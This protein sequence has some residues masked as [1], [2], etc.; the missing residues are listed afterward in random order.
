MNIR[1]LAAFIL[2]DIV[3]IS[4]LACNGTATLTPT[5]TPTLT[6]YTTPDADWLGPDGETLTEY[7]PVDGGY[8]CGADGHRIELINNPNATNPDWQT[9]LAFLQADQTDRTLYNCSTFINPDY[10]ETLH[11]NAEASGIRTGVVSVEI[12]NSTS[13]S[14]SWSYLLNAFNVSYRGLIYIDDTGSDQYCS[15]PFDKTINLV[16]NQPFRPKFLFSNNCFYLDYGYSHIVRN[17]SVQWGEAEREYVPTDR[18]INGADGHFVQLIN[19]PEAKDPTW[20]ELKDFL[21]QDDTDTYLYNSSTFVCTDYAELLHNNAEEA[22]IRA[23]FVTT[24]F[25]NDSG[26]HAFNAFNTSDMGLLYIDDTGG[27]S[28]HPCSGDKLEIHLELGGKY[29]PIAI[30]P[31]QNS[32]LISMS[33][34]RGNVSAIYTQ[35]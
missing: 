19:N 14:L 12:N 15:S 2:L 1:K 33:E 24:S 32:S 16:L 5:T 4:C 13:G 20:Q 3:L 7:V 21:E 35:W 11:N 10:A 18:Y 25:V 34:S 22:G 29:T 31:C 28:P 6:T 27:Y 17:I 8:W 26:G 9:L 23:A 30:F